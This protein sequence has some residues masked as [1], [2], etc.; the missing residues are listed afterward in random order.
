MTSS[1]TA[2]RRAWRFGTVVM[3]ST[4]RLP[5][6]PGGPPPAGCRRHPPPT[7]GGGPEAEELR[8]RVRGGSYQ[9]ARPS[10]ALDTIRVDPQAAALPS[11]PPPIVGGG[12]RRQPAGGGHTRVR[13]I[14]DSR[15]GWRA[16]RK[17]TVR[18]IPA[19]VHR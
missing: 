1:G 16:T 15:T 14:G 4:R 11:G 18:I 12:C 10:D 3:A 8:L 9:R 19:A 5:P 2:A 17:R 7:I 13:A 6:A